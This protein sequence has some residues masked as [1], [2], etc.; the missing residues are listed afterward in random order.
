MLVEG[1]RLRLR[2]RRGRG[3]QIAEHQD[4]AGGGVEADRLAVVLVVLAEILEGCRRGGRRR[5]ADIRY[6]GR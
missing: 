6:D 4:D 5:G 1:T 3:G 2:G